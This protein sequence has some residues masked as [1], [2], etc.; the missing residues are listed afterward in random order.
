MNKRHNSNRSGTI[1]YGTVA[2]RD[3]TCELDEVAGADVRELREEGDQVVDTVADAV[4]RVEGWLDSGEDE[5]RAVGSSTTVQL[6]MLSKS[7]PLISYAYTY[8][9]GPWLREMA[10]ASSVM[11]SKYPLENPAM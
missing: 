9:A 3:S 4:V 2:E 5:H 6:S 8:A 7:C 10:M 11:N 1:T